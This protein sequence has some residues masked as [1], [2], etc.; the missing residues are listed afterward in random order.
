M[1]ASHSGA[2]KRLGLHYIALKKDNVVNK[3]VS[4]QRPI[5]TISSLPV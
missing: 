2:D 1:V 4:W 3:E 5:K